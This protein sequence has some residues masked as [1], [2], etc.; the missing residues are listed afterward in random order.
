LEDELQH[1]A[2]RANEFK[3]SADVLLATHEA[4]KSRAITIEET[5]ETLRKLTIKQDE[6]VRQSLRCVES[7]LYRAAHV[8]SW[9]ALMD[10]MEEQLGK[11]AFKTLNVVRPHWKV[12]TPEDLRDLG[13]DFQVIDALKDSGMCT[14][15]EEKALKGL[16][17]KRNECAHPTD[18]F[19]DLNQT[20]G[21]L[22]EILNRIATFQKRW[23]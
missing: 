17:N 4:S 14:K 9:A 12:K 8:L 3:K 11:D 23:K 2:R 21:Y 15:T 13:S 18:Y 7:S 22:S 5:Y 6:L 1:L 20:L 19:P 10:F 16:L